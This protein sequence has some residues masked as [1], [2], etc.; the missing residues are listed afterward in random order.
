VQVGQSDLW[1]Q[2]SPRACYS[3]L[4]TKLQTLGFVPLKGDNSLFFFKDQ[5]VTMYILVYVDNI[6]VVSSSEAATS[7]LLRNLE[8]DF[9]LKD[10][11]ELH[12]FP[13]IEVE[14]I[15][16]GILLSQN[17]YAK[18]LLKKWACFHVSWCEL[19][20]LLQRNF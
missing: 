15:N 2:A 17:K 4:S 20:C 3:Q 5:T 8:K 16:G 11:G 19:P 12:Y 13:G 9:A 6:I 7:T 10:L 18:D 14:K 1:S